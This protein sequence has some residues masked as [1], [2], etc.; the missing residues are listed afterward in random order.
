MTYSNIV[1]SFGAEAFCRACR[2]AGVSGLILPDLPPEEAVEIEAAG[3]KNGVDLIYFLAPTSSEERIKLVA[4]RSSGFIYLVSVAGVTGARKELPPDL[5]E[6]VSRVKRETNKPVCVGF[7]ILTPE[8]ASEVASVADGVIVG[9]RI[10]Q[11]MEN[12]G[13][14]AAADFVKE[15]RHAIDK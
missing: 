1:M 11:L 6:F 5:S 9:S 8:Q 2:E 10:I 4:A 12:G 13:T 3:K 15:M 14:K 7:G